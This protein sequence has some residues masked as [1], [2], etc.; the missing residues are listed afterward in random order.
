MLP[1]LDLATVFLTNSLIAGV[2]ALVL[3]VLRRNQPGIDGIGYW[4]AGQGAYAIGF[5]L[6]YLS[7]TDAFQPTALPGFFFSFAGALFTS[8]GFHRF[9]DLPR[10][11]VRAAAGAF[12]AALLLLPLLS[13]TGRTGLI[14]AATTAILGSSAALNAWILLRNGKGQLRPAA[15]T[16]AAQHGCWALFALA[17]LIFIAVN[18][19]DRPAA[20]STL[21]PAMLMATVMLTCHALGRSGWWWDACRNIWWSR[22]RP[23][24]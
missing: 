4:A 14:V 20:I 9:L 5:L 8:L 23:T 22:R 15:L 18:G 21:V 13:L 24:R 17:R 2:T 12:L 11:A 10:R 6:L 1:A 19:F 3:T 16:L 7:M